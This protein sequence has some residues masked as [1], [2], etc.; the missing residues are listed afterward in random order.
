M[1][2]SDRGRF[3]RA[4]RR[5]GL[6]AAVRQASRSWIRTNS[7]TC[8]FSSTTQLRTQLNG[9]ATC[10]PSETPSSDFSDTC[11]VGRR[12]LRANP[13]LPRAAPCPQSLARRR[14][15]CV[16]DHVP[17]PRGVGMPRSLSAAA[18]ARNEDAPARLASSTTAAR[19][20]ARDA[21]RA[22]C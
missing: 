16:A 19:S 7:P 4:L 8:L 20:F 22:A 21:A 6:I 12:R 9:S 2:E 18:R 14:L 5:R 11:I 1:G 3:E 15:T 10:P 13:E 17:D